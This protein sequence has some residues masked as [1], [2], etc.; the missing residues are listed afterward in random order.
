MNLK[1]KLWLSHVGFYV[2][3]I[4]KMVGFYT[5][6]LGFTVSDRGPRPDGE[7][8]F[9]TRDASEHHQLVFATGRPSDLSFNVINQI[10]FR[11]DGL[12]TLREMHAALKDNPVKILG[13][14][15][16]GNALSSYFLDPEGNRVELLIGTPW[17][18]PQPCR[19]PVDLSLP[20]DQMWASIEKQVCTM[21]GFKTHAEWEREMEAKLS[22]S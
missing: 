14:V 12:D 5:R 3:D 19:L 8:V 11:L 20:D 22:A 9:M 1:G 18:V 4:N 16:H 6:F 2:T 7:I 17:Y 21:P 15:T 10:S 13:P